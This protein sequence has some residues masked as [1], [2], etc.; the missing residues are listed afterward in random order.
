QKAKK[1]LQRFGFRALEPT[2]MDKIDNELSITFV[3]NVDGILYY[4]KIIK[5]KVGMD[6][7]DV[8]AFEGTQYYMYDR[9]RPLNKLL[10]TEA[11]AKKNINPRLKILR[12][13]KA[14]ILN[15]RNQEV[16]TY[17]FLGELLGEKYLIY[18]NTE[19]G[20]EEKIVRLKEFKITPAKDAETVFN[21]E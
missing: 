2:E 11:E 10:L 19:T 4:P 3:S 7:G 20:K 6:R 13:R 17:E 9:P 14:V 16:L 5:V 8:T 1:Y 12:T 21:Y 18:V 15:D